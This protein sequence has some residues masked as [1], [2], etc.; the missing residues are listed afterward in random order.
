MNF[1][2]QVIFYTGLLLMGSTLVLAII[3]FFFRKMQWLKLSNQ[4]DEEYGKRNKKKIR[5]E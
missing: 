3:C 2:N 1:S 4:L 5:G